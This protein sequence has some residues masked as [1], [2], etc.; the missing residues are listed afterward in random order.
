MEQ[1]K[2]TSFAN[3]IRNGRTIADFTARMMKLRRQQSRYDTRIIYAFWELFSDYSA[4]STI[5]GVRYMGEK[6]NFRSMHSLICKIF[7]DV[8]QRYLLTLTKSLFFTF[9]VTMF[10]QILHECTIS[11]NLVDKMFFS[12]CKISGSFSLV[13]SLL[14]FPLITRKRY[15]LNE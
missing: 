2:K 3:R 10:K 12:F 4:Y 9:C 15:Q 6:V 5:H 13:L 11:C 7:I 14:M 8:C 1:N